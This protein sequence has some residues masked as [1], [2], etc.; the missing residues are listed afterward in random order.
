VSDGAG[1]LGDKLDCLG[2]APRFDDREPGYRRD[3]LM[4]GPLSVSTSFGVAYLHRCSGYTHLH[5]LARNAA[6]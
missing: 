6:S 5:P 3:E 2:E 1:G 4:N